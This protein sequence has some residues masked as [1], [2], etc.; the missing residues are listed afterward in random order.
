MINAKI[1]FRNKG[2][3]P[4]NVHGGLIKAGH[5]YFIFSFENHAYKAIHRSK[6]DEIQIIN[7][8]ERNTDCQ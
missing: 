2:G 1:K 6:I 4:C 3:H 5:Y 8:N 7:L